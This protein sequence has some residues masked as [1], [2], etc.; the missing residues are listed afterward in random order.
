MT[1][2]VIYGKKITIQADEFDIQAPVE[3]TQTLTLPQD[4]LTPVQNKMIISD[5][6]GSVV[7]E[8]PALNGPPI[9]LPA[10]F[11]DYRVLFGMYLQQPSTGFTI[12]LLSGGVIGTLSSN[13]PLIVFPGFLPL[14]YRPSV[15]QFTAVNGFLLIGAVATPNA[16]LCKWLTNGDLQLYKNTISDPWNSGD[17]FSLNSQTTVVLQITS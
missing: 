3:F 10:S 1:E 5:S 6:F 12:A 13:T 7:F 4:P 17:R 9:T 8:T 15:E 14:G 16:F 2:R 11:L